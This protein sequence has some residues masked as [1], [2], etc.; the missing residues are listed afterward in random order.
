MKPTLVFDCEC[1]LDYFLVAFRNIDTGNVVS[2]ERFEGQPLDVAKVRKIMQSYTLISFNGNHYDLPVLAMALTG[3]DCATIRSVSDDIIVAKVKPWAIYNAHNLSEFE[4]LDH[5]DII[6]VA[7]GMI[8][9]KQYGGR[10]HAPTLQDLPFDPSD[11]IT[12]DRRPVLRQYCANDLALTEQLYRHLLPQIDVRRSMTAEYGI[13]L[14][15]KSDAQIAE[16]VI[17]HEVEAKLGNKK[18][19]RPILP[20]NTKLKYSPPDWLRFTTRA[21]NDAFN[22]LCDAQYT[23]DTWGSPVMPEAMENATVLIGDS[24][25]RLGIGGIHSSESKVAHRSDVDH[26]LIDRDVAAYYPSIILR[27][28]LAPAGMGKHFS[29]VYGGIVYR[30]LVAKRNKNSVVDAML[31]IV[32]NGSF[33]KLGSKWSVLYAPSLFLQV[34]LTGQL[35]LLMLIEMLEKHGIPVVSANTDGVVIKCPRALLPE[36][37]VIVEWWESVTHFVTEETKY[38]ALYSRDVNNYVALKTD[39][40]AKTKGVFSATSLAKSPANEVCNCAVVAYLN[41][42]TPVADT[43]HACHDI[44]KFLTLRQVKGGAIWNG[45]HLGRVVRWYYTTTGGAEIRDR[46]SNNTVAR[47][48]GCRPCMT[49]PDAFPTDVNLDW[50][51]TE[52][53][54]MLADLGVKLAPAPQAELELVAA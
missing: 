41:N 19:V 42:G 50:Y 47:S 18:L 40:K 13:D 10:L 51:I 49:L 7:P 35:A 4:D 6:E 9:L 8:G 28:G 29:E 43:I 31:K 33:G 17:K 25:Y 30:R 21:G 32:I 16:A 11:G 24:E 27:C 22:L 45:Q 52:A 20:A 5:I 23:L 53:E 48:A 12:P 36:L 34:T 37:D 44:R 39:G 15:S 54:S 3:A 2:F 1:Y 46:G 14:R 38:T 26:V